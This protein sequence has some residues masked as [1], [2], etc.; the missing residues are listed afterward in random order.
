MLVIVLFFYFCFDANDA[1]RAAF[2]IYGFFF[3]V[4]EFVFLRRTSVAV[5]DRENANT[6]G[7]RVKHDKFNFDRF[8]VSQRCSCTWRFWPAKS[9]YKIVYNNNNFFFLL[10][11]VG[12]RRPPRGR[13]T[14]L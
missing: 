7:G 3:L 10:S 11:R 5:F 1:R 12:R 14:I 13:S 2:S 4:L 6:R 8:C 9:D